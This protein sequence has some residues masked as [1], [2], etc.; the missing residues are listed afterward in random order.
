MVGLIYLKF[1]SARN[2]NLR[3]GLIMTHRKVFINLA[4]NN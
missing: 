2:F 4:D 3:R 1:I